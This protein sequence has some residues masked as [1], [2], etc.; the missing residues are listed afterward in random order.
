MLNKDKQEVFDALN[1]IKE[2][3]LES[4]KNDPVIDKQPN[5]N[6]LEDVIP[7]NLKDTILFKL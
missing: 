7:L 5:K 4:I 3:A 1:I 6:T 2:V